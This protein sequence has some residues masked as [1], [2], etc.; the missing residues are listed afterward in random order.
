MCDTF[1]FC[2]IVYAEIRCFCII[3]I[4]F[5]FSKINSTG[6]FTIYYEINAFLQ[7]LLAGYPTQGLGE[8]ALQ[9]LLSQFESIVRRQPEFRQ[10][11]G[12]S[13]FSSLP[14]QSM[15]RL[16][17]GFGAAVDY[18]AGGKH[19]GIDLAAPADAQRGEPVILA[20]EAGTV[21]YVGPLYCAADDACR[22]DHA[23]VIDHGNDVYSVY[24]HNSEASVEAGQ[25]VSAGQPIA[26]QGDEGYSFGSHLHFEVHTGAPFSGDWTEPFK[27]GQFEDPLKWLPE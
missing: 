16:T 5:F 24:S 27:G 11:N 7:P 22:G 17:R 12:V 25:P 2:F 3:C 6:Q 18:Q 26:R 1:N 8:E 23:V 19:T 15:P 14:Y 20:V 9:G 21:T 13:G 10:L 4:H